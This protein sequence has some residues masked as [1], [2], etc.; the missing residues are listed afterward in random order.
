M[1]NKS[2]KIQ[3]SVIP[4]DWNPKDPNGYSNW[5]KMIVQENKNASGM[6]KD[7]NKP[8]NEFITPEP[9]FIGEIIQEFTSP[10]TSQ[11]NKT[12]SL[13]KEILNKDKI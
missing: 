2:L 10:E 1:R 12:V 3:K 7:P 13:A 11:M 5:M 6:F 9:R 8:I 4:L